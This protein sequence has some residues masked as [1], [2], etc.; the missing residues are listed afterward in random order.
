MLFSTKAEYGVRLMVEQHQRDDVAVR[1][2]VAAE[3]EFPL[4][5]RLRRDRLRTGCRHLRLDHFD[6]AK[7]VFRHPR[8]GDEPP[9]PP[10]GE[11]RRVIHVPTVGVLVVV[12]TGHGSQHQ[13]A[14]HRERVP[15]EMARQT[16]VI[17]RE[18]RRTV[19]RLRERVV[20]GPLRRIL[21]G[22]FQDVAAAHPTD[23]N[24]I[25][26]VDGARIFVVD[27]P[28]LEARFRVDE[29]LRFDGQVEGG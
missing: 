16:V 20:N 2:R 21:C 18:P 13:R 23:G 1:R 9:A 19:R 17:A 29:H 22:D 7:L 15:G 3:I 25:V 14:R 11:R 6:V 26:E 27:L 8:S 28:R 24:A 5:R 4:D 10:I 12:A